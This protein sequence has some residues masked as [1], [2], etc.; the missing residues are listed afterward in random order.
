MSDLGDAIWWREKGGEGEGREKNEG[1]I[2]RKIE[3]KKRGIT[4]KDREVGVRE[5]DGERE[6]EWEEREGVFVREGS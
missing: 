3:A 4:K 5:M 2:K 6:Y 1:Y